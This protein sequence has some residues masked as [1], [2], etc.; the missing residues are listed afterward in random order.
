MP[1]SSITDAEAEKE[2]LENNAKAIE[3]RRTSSW[4]NDPQVKDRFEKITPDLSKRKSE[5]P[6]RKEA[7]VAKLHLPLFPTTTIGSFPQTKQI[8]QARNKLGKKEITEEE[9]EKFIEKE[10]E[11][12][13]KFQEEVGLDV[14]VHGEPERNDMVCILLDSD[15]RQ[16]QYFGERLKGFVFTQNGWVQSF[17]SRYVRPPIVV[18]DVSRPHPMTVKESKYA[19]GLTKKPSTS[20]FNQTNV[21]V[22]GMLTGPITI[23]RWSFPRDDIPQSVQAKQLGLALRDEVSDLEKAGISVIQVDGAQVCY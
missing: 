15:L 7:Q 2:Y 13:I 6:T 4:T 17:G 22:K 18:G 5:Y 1:K 19:V 16:V 14:F 12:M 11:E 20:S 23:L 3:S 10:I 8:R 9:Y 21:L